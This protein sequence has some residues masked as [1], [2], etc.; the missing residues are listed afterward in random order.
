LLL[1]V[2]CYWVSHSL[3]HTTIYSVRKKGNIVINNTP[4]QNCHRPE[5]SQTMPSLNL[6]ERKHSGLHRGND[7][8]MN[9]RG[10]YIMKVYENK[11]L[12][13]IFRSKRDEMLGGWRK[14]NYEKLHN[15]YSSPNIIRTNKSRRLK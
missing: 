1:Y 13:R 15:L 11:M 8:K 12:R 3:P 5:I 9:I 6:V 4:T 7:I 2:A 14:Q 10:K